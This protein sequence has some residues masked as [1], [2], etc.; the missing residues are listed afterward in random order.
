MLV[1]V[2][3]QIGKMALH[4]I[5]RDAPESYLVGDEYYVAAL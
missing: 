3:L 4:R 2:T 1:Y 5:F